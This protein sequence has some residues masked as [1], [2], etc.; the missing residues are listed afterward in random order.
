MVSR[1]QVLEE[2]G[3]LEPTV[4]PRLVELVFKHPEIVLMTTR[5]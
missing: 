1:A 2:Q 4:S 5:S 3:Q